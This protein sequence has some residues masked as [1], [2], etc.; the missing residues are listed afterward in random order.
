MRVKIEDC[1]SQ[2]DKSNNQVTDDGV[3][4]SAKKTRAGASKWSVLS[5]LRAEAFNLESGRPDMR[6]GRGQPL[7]SKRKEPTEQS[8]SRLLAQVEP[9]PARSMSKVRPSG[10]R[11][12]GKT[13]YCGP[14]VTGAMFA[15]LGLWLLLS[16]N[17]PGSPLCSSATGSQVS[18][19]RVPLRA[20]IELGEPQE[21]FE[22]EL[23]WRKNNGL[24]GG[25]LSRV[26]NISSSVG[27]NDIPI[28]VGLAPTAA[29]H[30]DGDARIA[31]GRVSHSRLAQEAR[32][33]S[34]NESNLSNQSNLFVD[35]G[36]E[37]SPADNTDIMQ[38]DEEVADRP[39]LEAGSIASILPTRRPYNKCNS[40][41]YKKDI[42]NRSQTTV[43]SRPLREPLV[44]NQVAPAEISRSRLA[45]QGPSL[46]RHAEG[47]RSKVAVRRKRSN[48]DLLDLGSSQVQPLWLSNDYAGRP[49][50]PQPC[51]LQSALP[52]RYRR[53]PVLRYN[54]KARVS[55]SA[56]R[57]N[58]VGQALIA[59]G[60]DDLFLEPGSLSPNFDHAAF[61]QSWQAAGQVQGRRHAKRDGNPKPDSYRDR[62]EDWLEFADNK[63]A[64]I[65]FGGFFPWLTNDQDS[66]SQSADQSSPFGTRSKGVKPNMEQHLN[67]AEHRW[68]ERH[69]KRS[70]PQLANS[71]VTNSSSGRYQLGRF[72]LPA[73][74]LALDHINKNSTLL[75]SYR[76][77]IVP[78]DTQVSNRK[79]LVA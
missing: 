38:P 72:L 16:L 21:R 42:D 33:A 48:E 26:L 54:H 13:S 12:V 45:E 29:P 17:W 66:A 51:S 57:D 27:H 28:L 31:R 10:G 60:D 69:E 62:A 25:S 73:V 78:R 41:R 20:T 37:D 6:R 71:L 67:K 65:Y 30:Y 49:G 40:S 55:P 18:S 19:I 32:Q 1:K 52:C 44:S 75:S 74:R 2:E 63:L 70:N 3:S 68:E 47:A 56:I 34:D 77:E 50:N 46:G 14:I 5:W 4:S 64:T 58:H 9:R 8:V 43:S 7:S 76:L 23:N 61:E 79:V 11:W 35:K 36:C 22:S 24:P 59:A 39:E 53:Q 15:Q